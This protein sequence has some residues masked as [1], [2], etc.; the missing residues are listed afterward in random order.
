[1]G[2]FRNLSSSVQIS[3]IILNPSSGKVFSTLRLGYGEGIFYLHF[4]REFYD[5][6]SKG[7]TTNLWQ[8]ITQLFGIVIVKF[9]DTGIH[10]SADMGIFRGLCINLNNVHQTLKT[11]GFFLSI[12]VN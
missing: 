2:Q 11:S 8:G 1:M 7:N 6:L 10:K 9:Y 3:M 12:I 4:G 5:T